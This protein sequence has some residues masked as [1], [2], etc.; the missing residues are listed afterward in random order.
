VAQAERDASSPLV[1]GD[2]SSSAGSGG[3]RFQGGNAVKF[4]PHQGIYGR[5]STLSSRIQQ[6]ERVMTGFETA[7]LSGV[8]AAMLMFAVSVFWVSTINRPR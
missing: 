2:V 3:T 6:Q 4:D 7:Y 8:L 1:G 5:K